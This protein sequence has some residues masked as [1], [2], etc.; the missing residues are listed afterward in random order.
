MSAAKRYYFMTTRTHSTSRIV[1]LPRVSFLRSRRHAT[2][3]RPTRVT[4]SEDTMTKQIEEEGKKAASNS[5][6]LPLTLYTTILRGISIHQRAEKC[7]TAI[8][9]SDDAID[10]VRVGFSFLYCI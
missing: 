10:T 1:K 3:E 5:R 8:L 4:L 9:L 7:K 2:C 6:F